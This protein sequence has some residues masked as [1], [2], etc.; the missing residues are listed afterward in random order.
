MQATHI[1]ARNS[2]FQ[3]DDSR[4]MRSG[5]FDPQ[6][7]TENSIGSVLRGGMMVNSNKMGPN[8]VTDTVHMFFMPAGFPHGVDLR[9]INIMRG[10]DHGLAGKIV[11]VDFVADDISVTC[12]L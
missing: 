7:L 4:M 6:M 1:V 2:L 10:R 12:K 9:S 3:I 8:W 11:F 5:W